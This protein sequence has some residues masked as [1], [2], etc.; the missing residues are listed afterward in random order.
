MTYR[1]LKHEG[2]VKRRRNLPAKGFGRESCLRRCGCDVFGDIFC[3]SIFNRYRKRTR[4]KQIRTSYLDWALLQIGC[5]KT[6]RRRRN[7][8][9]AIR[10]CGMA[11]VKS[12][13]VPS[14]S[15][16]ITYISRG[17]PSLGGIGSIGGGAGLPSVGGKYQWMRTGVSFS[18]MADG[19][20]KV[21]ETYL[22]SG[23]NGW[24]KYIYS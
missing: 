5:H 8:Y 6:P 24:N 17:K 15:G 4:G 12:Y 9:G 3:I 21:S 2:T 22:L 23:P 13:L 11:G 14:Y 18:S 16:T 10:G 20:Y 19:K 7:N 1:P